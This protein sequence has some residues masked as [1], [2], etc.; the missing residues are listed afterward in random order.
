MSKKRI[1]V[2]F[3]NRILLSIK[4]AVESGPYYSHS[5]A[6]EKAVRDKFGP[7]KRFALRSTEKHSLATNLADPDNLDENT[8]LTFRLPSTVLGRVER[9]ADRGV[10]MNASAAIRDA[11]REAYLEEVPVHVRSKSGEV[12]RGKRP[13][14]PEGSGR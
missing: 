12:S 5:Q 14:A 9:A 13:A 4:D 3:P 7:P 6:I 1:T 2:R 11:V 10:Y 8:R